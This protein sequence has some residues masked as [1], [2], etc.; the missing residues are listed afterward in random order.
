MDR[1]RCANW[2]VNSCLDSSGCPGCRPLFNSSIKMDRCSWQNWKN[3]FA[4]LFGAFGSFSCYKSKTKSKIRFRNSY[5][6]V[7]AHLF[8]LL[9]LPFGVFA[10]GNGWFDIGVTIAAFN[11]YRRVCGVLQFAR[12]SYFTSWREIRGRFDFGQWIRL[13]RSPL[14]AVHIQSHF[15]QINVT[16]LMRYYLLDVVESV[17]RTQNK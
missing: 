2:R 10:F 4:G 5:F 17:D 3:G 16:L 6:I 9:T 14:V 7:S 12:F 13:C 1:H 11:F 8:Q 15:Q